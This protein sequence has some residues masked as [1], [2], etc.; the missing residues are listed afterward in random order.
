MRHRGL[1]YLVWVAASTIAL[2]QE[3]PDADALQHSIE[4]LRSSIGRWQVTTEYLNPDG[5]VA[6][7]VE[8]S[9]EFS[10]IVPDRVVTGKSEIPE[11]GQT[12]GI[13]FYIDEARRE[14]EMSAVGADG[15]LWVMTGPLGG[16]V[17]TTPDYRTA[18]GGTGR[19]RFTRFQVTA[20]A[21]ESRMEY[22]ED[23]G[24]T[25]RAGNH[26][27]FRRVR[28]AAEALAEEVRR[29]EAAFAASLAARDLAAF[30][31]HVA[32]DAVFF[33]KGGAQRGKAAVLEGW[34]SYFQGPDAPFAWKPESVE[35]LPS[36]RLAWSSGPVL[37]PTGKQVAR[38]NSIWRQDDD[39]R[40]RV[41]LDRGTSCDGAE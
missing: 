27:R 10:W 40:W 2:A 21:F 14:I 6:R 35:L 30:A 1:V 17:R 29:A 32:D 11:L 26:Q 36:G 13:L 18:E 31:G 15:K 7:S 16:E 38:F 28:P 12:S 4:Q 39:G 19:L 37:D 9:Y 33:G 3:S 41:I 23:G 22:T 8:G 24:A 34:R 5:S 25:W 20:D